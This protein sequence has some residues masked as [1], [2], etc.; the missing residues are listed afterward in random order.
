MESRLRLSNIPRILSRSETIELAAWIESAKLLQKNT[1]W[2]VESNENNI[3]AKSKC[4][5][6]K[7]N[8]DGSEF[9]D[10]FHRS[11]KSLS[12]WSNIKM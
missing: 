9:L 2:T 12:M 5:K 7:K 3:P 1:Q 10:L 11:N 6:K 8:D 4:F